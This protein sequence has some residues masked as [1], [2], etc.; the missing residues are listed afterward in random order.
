MDSGRRAKRI[1]RIKLELKIF[2]AL[3]IIVPWILVII[4]FIKAY[5][6]KE[7]LET[8]EKLN[9]MYLDQIEMLSSEEGV[10]GWEED[11]ISDYGVES[12]KSGEGFSEAKEKDI[13]KTPS[14]SESEKVTLS[15][16]EISELTLS[17]EALYDGYRKVYLTFDDGPSQ[18]TEEILDILKE[19]NVKATFFVIK[20]EGREYEELYRRI[21]NEGHTLGMHST[22]HVYS[23]IYSSTEA[24]VND[25]VKLRDFLY[26]VTGVESNYYR[27][28]GGSSNK[29]SSID[30]KVFA[31]LLEDMGIE[32]FDWNV[33][34]QDASSPILSKNQ[35]V[36]N[37][38]SKLYNFDCAMILFHDTNSK[39]TTVEALPEI[40]EYINSMEKTVI[41]PI[42]EDTNPIQHVSVD[43]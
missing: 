24:F 23:N 40:I 15:D 19:Y 13:S 41:L 9:A 33:S 12:E 3:L 18:N 16:K 29:V 21:V 28:P 38:V 11:Y 43:K 27:F 42:G 32:Y 36:N 7:R 22:D 6:K 8:A 39:V 17:N 4:L 20:K 1:K 30:M 5:D 31:S 10:R 2:K 37:A 14:F 35:I 26:M 25:T 34:S